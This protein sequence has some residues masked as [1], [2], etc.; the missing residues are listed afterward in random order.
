[1]PFHGVHACPDF[2]TA[3]EVHA[4]RLVGGKG[5]QIEKT[6]VAQPHTLRCHGR[7]VNPGA[8]VMHPSWA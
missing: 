8:L 1:V 3:K 5:R 7:G 6:E 2:V 4:L